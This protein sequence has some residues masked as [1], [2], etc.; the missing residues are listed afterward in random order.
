MIKCRWRK[1]W[2]RMEWRHLFLENRI[3]QDASLVKEWRY[4][5]TTTTRNDCLIFK[6]R[7]KKK[8][9]SEKLKRLARFLHS[10]IL[11]Q[12]WSI[13]WCIIENH[14]KDSEITCLFKEKKI[15]DFDFYLAMKKK[16]NTSAC[17][18]HCCGL[19]WSRVV[20]LLCVSLNLLCLCKY[21]GLISVLYFANVDRCYWFYCKID[22]DK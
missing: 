14:L 6:N 20:Y 5:D 13:L 21:I 18:V 4:W 3:N 11:T 8:K 1:G 10:Y 7:K 2:R 9:N 16:K 22:H 15:D 19:I 12:I 17:Y